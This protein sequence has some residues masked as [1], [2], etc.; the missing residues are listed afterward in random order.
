MSNLTTLLQ[1]EPVS[2]YTTL[3]LFL[4]LLGGI[5]WY[6]ARATKSLSDFLVM[7]G[8]AGAVVGGFAYFASQYSMSTFMGVPAMTYSTGFAGMSVS[9]PGL[10]FSMLIPALFVGRKLMLMGRR[11]NLMTMSDYLSDRYESNAIR[12]V[13]AVM[14]VIFLIAMM[15]AQTVGAGVI[16]NTFTGL[17]EWIGVV[18]MGAVVVLY[19]M[20]GGM[21]GAMMTDVLQGGLMVAT[22]VVTFIVSVHAG[23]GME[24]ITGKL[25][26]EMPSHLTH[27]GAKG[28]SLG[29]PM[30]R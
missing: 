4:L 22:A 28:T 1:P 27:P 17:P 16:L 26:T 25:A 29:R 14:M 18:V 12:G 30:S 10:A 23:G 15:G 2:F 3:S 8:K 20:I 21:T 5:G 6:A 11:Y 24:V 19:C 7:G 9:V 13:H